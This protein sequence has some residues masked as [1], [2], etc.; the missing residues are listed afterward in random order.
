LT[1]LQTPFALLDDCGATAA[2]PTSRVYSGYVRTH[3]CTDPAALDATWAQVDADQRQGLHAVLLADYEWGAKLQRAGQGGLAQDDASALSALMFRDCAKLSA[4]EVS[5]WLAARERAEAEAQHG[6]LGGLPVA[7]ID[8][9]PSIDEAR[10]STTRSLRARPTRST[11][12][13]ACTAGARARRWRCTGAC[14][15]VRLLPT[16]R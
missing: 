2:R 7:V 9:Q 16:A 15:N 11:S 3:R 1:T 10:T 14:A 6:P 8:L 4:D 13:T 12:P 5:A